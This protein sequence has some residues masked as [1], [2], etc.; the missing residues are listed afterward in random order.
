MFTYTG[1]S[2]SRVPRSR[3]LRAVQSPTTGKHALSWRSSQSTR[4]RSVPGR[5]TYFRSSAEGPPWQLRSVSTSS[6]REGGTVPPSN[7]KQ[8]SETYL[9]EVSIP[10][11]PEITNTRYNHF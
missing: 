8:Y 10:L 9:F 2:V 11:L 4:R 7:R 5:G 1:T 3:V 6:S